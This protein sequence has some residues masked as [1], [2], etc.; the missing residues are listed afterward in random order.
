MP[1]SGADSAAKHEAIEEGCELSVNG[2]TD[3]SHMGASWVGLTSW[4]GGGFSHGHDNACGSA[5]L[6]GSQVSL[7]KLVNES[8]IH[9]PTFFCKEYV[10]KKK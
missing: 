3:L 5:G 2:V 4:T 6:P 1:E 8:T 10:M 9:T 7:E